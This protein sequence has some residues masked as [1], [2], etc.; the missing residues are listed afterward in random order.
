[1]GGEIVFWNLLIYLAIEGLKWLAKPVKAVNGAKTYI[2][3]AIIAG[4]GVTYFL[5]RPESF[6]KTGGLSDWI[7]FDT[8][9]LLL[10]VGGG[11]ALTGLRHAFSKLQ[12]ATSPTVFTKILEAME[13]LIQLLE[14][15][16]SE[17]KNRPTPTP[18]AP[19][20]TPPTPTPEP[21]P[22]TNMTGG[23]IA[24]ALLTLASGSVYAAPPTI[25]IIGPPTAAAGELITLEAVAS[26]DSVSI[27]W[28][29]LGE[30]SARMF[31][32]IPG[33]PS[34][35]RI[36]TYPGSWVYIAVASNGTEIAAKSHTITII[37]DGPLPGPN[38]L[39][40][41]PTPPL[42][43]PPNPTPPLPVPPN[44]PLP[45]PPAP[46]PASAWSQ[47]IAAMAKRV[48]SAQRYET[49]L[50]VAASCEELAKFIKD[51][52]VSGVRPILA[53]MSARFSTELGANQPAW[54]EFSDFFANELQKMYMGGLL[55]NDEA[56][57]N[58]LRQTA[59]GLR[60]AV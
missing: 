34:K 51:G 10:S 50:K 19:P 23:M 16:I 58:I 56:W 14:Q 42:P 45:T 49:C 18:P 40:P 26:A 53:S 54:K 5:T 20:P 55:S 33:A 27:T 17:F 3:S 11:I 7:D 48:N 22:W 37:K 2:G 36:A 12:S 60:L 8:F 52:K 1:M 47:Q 32:P 35:V 39:P 46:E 43:V 41:S 28:T 31:E 59:A 21:W 24:F 15:V 25:S 38:P 13:Y 29:M 4:A 57:I 6:V 44:P 30:V 9:M